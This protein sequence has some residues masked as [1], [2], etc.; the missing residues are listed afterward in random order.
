MMICNTTEDMIALGRKIGNSLKGGEC[1]ELLGDVG[2]GKTTLTKGIAEALEADDEIQSPSFT[3]ARQYNC[4]DGLS[5][6]HY[7]FYRLPDP[8]LMVHELDE[9]LADPRGITII[10]WA[11]TVEAVLPKDRIRIQIQ[12]TADSKADQRQVIIQGLEI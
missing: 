9:A 6:R 11:S 10:E 4:R 5:L 8:G 12:I 3:I 2:S 7:D 1:L